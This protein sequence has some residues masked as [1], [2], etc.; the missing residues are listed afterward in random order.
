M[1]ISLTLQMGSWTG[2]FLR[3]EIGSSGHRNRNSMVPEIRS[4]AKVTGRI[5]FGWS[6]FTSSRNAH[7]PPSLISLENCHFISEEL[8]YF[9]IYF[10]R[11]RVD[12]DFGPEQSS[13]PQATRAVIDCQ[14]L[15]SNLLRIKLFSKRWK[16]FHLLGFW[17]FRWI[18]LLNK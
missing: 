17:D 6:L 14:S 12:V 9:A 4:N 7:A 8:L 5:F 3:I 2:S 13:L 15:V 10:S 18:T 11:E 1:T 16:C